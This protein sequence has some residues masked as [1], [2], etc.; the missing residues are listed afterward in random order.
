MQ[1]PTSNA[2]RHVPDAP[3][4][5]LPINAPAISTLLLQLIQ[6]SFG[7]SGLLPNMAASSSSLLLSLGLLAVLIGLHGC[8][9][10]FGQASGQG[11]WPFGQQPQQRK[12]HPLRFRSECRLDRLD[13]LE[14]SRRVE[15][16]A[17]FT[18][19]WDEEDNQ[20][21]CVGAAAVRHV[22]R[23]NGLFLPTFTNAP[24]L[25]YVLQGETKSCVQLF[26]F[27]AQSDNCYHCMQLVHLE[28][29]A[30]IFVCSSFPEQSDE[31]AL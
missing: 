28:T 21:T 12:R 23:R 15:A 19:L 9:A 3:P 5:D 2:A 7:I 30:I 25:L 8:S 27:D 31:R 13:T 29:S 11:P 14:P 10:H 16:E 17:G 20:F 26:L 6:V 18:E 4:L 1:T 22:I 24:E